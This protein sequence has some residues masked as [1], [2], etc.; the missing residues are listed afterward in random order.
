MKNIL[1]LLLIGGWLINI[2]YTHIDQEN[3]L[4]GLS[5]GCEVVKNV[6]VSAGI[7]FD[8][9]IHRPFDLTPAYTKWRQTVNVGVTYVFNI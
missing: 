6:Y 2:Q 1:A 9:D 5:I 8:Y 3:D 4:L 7:N